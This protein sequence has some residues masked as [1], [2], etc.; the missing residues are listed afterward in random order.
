[1]QAT[2][3]RQ[4]L[5]ASSEQVQQQQDTNARLKANLSSAHADAQTARTQHAAAERQAQRL[6]A[7][8]EQLQAGGSSAARI[9]DLHTQLTQSE[10]ALASAKQEHAAKVQTLREEHHRRALSWQ[11]AAG[12]AMHTGVC[13]YILIYAL[14]K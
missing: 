11:T 4:Q 5:A 8:L 13:C 12:V 7:E 3:L 2:D 1:M 10:A 14:G 6:G 9:K